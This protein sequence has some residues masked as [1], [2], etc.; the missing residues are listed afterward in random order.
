[1]K[2]VNRPRLLLIPDN[3]YWVLGHLAH[4]LASKI[5][6][7]DTSVVSL[8][9]TQDYPSIF[10]HIRRG[11]DVIHMLTPYRL[12]L[13]NH[14]PDR[15]LVAT[16]N[17]VNPG[18]HDVVRAAAAAQVV[19]IPSAEW[20]DRVASCLPKDVCIRR[21]PYGLDTE[22]FRPAK[23][24]RL[25]ILRRKYGIPRESFVIGFFASCSGLRDRK[26]SDV[27][28]EALRILRGTGKQITIL[29]TGPQVKGLRQEF[30]ESG[31]SFIR[32]PFI[33]SHASMAECYQLLDAYCITSRM[34]GGPVTL[35]ESMSCALPVVATPVGLVRDICRHGENALI[36]PKDNPSAVADQ[37]VRLMNGRGL[38]ER[39]GV[40]ARESVIRE[41]DWLTVAPRMA[42][43]Y[44][45][46]LERWR[47]RPG[48]LKDALPGDRSQPWPR[49][50]WSSL[51]AHD[52]AI[53]GN[54]ISAA[55]E[56]RTAL[57][58]AAAILLR[59]PFSRSGRRLVARILRK[60]PILWPLVRLKRSLLG[61]GTACNG[62]DTDN[63]AP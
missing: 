2:E 27:L 29:S 59:S 47:S 11:A 24:H 60:Q 42:D 56:D 63:S 41:C 50:S 49:V 51:F 44:R 5:I 46:A 43:I 18:R 33:M 62:T 21:V 25:A 15:A 19:H 45:E 40:K 36:V 57:R 34:E 38:R 1:M 12:D 61:T 23:P 28:V 6:E 8:S 10:D 3:A 9:Y 14:D 58:I 30:R 52:L 48:A 20:Q 7:F 39:L 16:I 22:V 54:R 32:R 26:G 31:M 4:A 37:L 53:V 13:L 35:L 55:G 17:H